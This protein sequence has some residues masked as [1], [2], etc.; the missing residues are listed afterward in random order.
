M[1]FSFSMEKFC[2]KHWMCCALTF[3]WRE[4]MTQVDGKDADVC[5]NLAEH[6]FA[7]LKPAAA[8][9]RQEKHCT[10]SGTSVSDIAE[11]HLDLRRNEATGQQ[12]GMVLAHSLN[13]QRHAVQETQVV[14]CAVK[15]LVQVCSSCLSALNMPRPNHTD[16]CL[17]KLTFGMIPCYFYSKH[18]RFAVTEFICVSYGLVFFMDSP[19]ELPKGRTRVA[20]LST[21][22]PS[23]S[24]LV[25]IFST[26]V[27]R[28][29]LSDD[30]F[31]DMHHVR[32]PGR[33][34]TDVSSSVISSISPYPIHGVAS[35]PACEGESL[36]CCWEV[37]WSPGRREGR[38][39]EAH[40]SICVMPWVG[41]VNDPVDAAHPMLWPSITTV[42][43]HCICLCLC[44]AA[45]VAVAACLK[46]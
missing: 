26:A 8:A 1:K 12:N 42:L 9:S 10:A 43:G 15:S 23:G 25:S 33:A 4:T 28:P 30:H 6:Y 19:P 2:S 14:S 45:V 32:R 11:C 46:I 39:Q 41:F 7:L 27:S 13:R 31:L 36:M 17:Q 40:C 3:T 34:G 24:S 21:P 18:L 22:S 38:G 44:S 37:L 16:I 5:F 35:S 20:S 29:R